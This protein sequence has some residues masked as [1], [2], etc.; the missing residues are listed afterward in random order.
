MKP[1]VLLLALMTVLPA[2]A[3]QAASCMQS[4]TAGQIAEGRLSHGQ[5]EDAAGRPEQAF[6][7]TLPTETCLAGSDEMDNVEDVKTIHVYASDEAIAAT[8]EGLVGKDV[9]VRGT[10]F[11]AH[12]AHHHAPVVMDVAEI[13][14]L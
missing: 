11:P 7:L 2:T 9:Q 1:A 10:P 14:G 4:N 5:F 13:D 12:T 3:A 6:I 8:L